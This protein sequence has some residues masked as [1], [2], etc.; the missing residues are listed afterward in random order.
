M[1]RVHIS[2]DIFFEDQVFEDVE[3]VSPEVVYSN[4]DNVTV[5]SIYL[6]SA[7]GKCPICYRIFDQESGRSGTITDYNPQLKAI[8]LKYQ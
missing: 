5:S 6:A 2:G 4:P 7:E 8:N 1:N 3:E